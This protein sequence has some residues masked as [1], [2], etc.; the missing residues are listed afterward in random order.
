MVGSWNVNV[1]NKMPQK[2]ASA[3]SALSEQLMGAEYDF[4]AYLGF[5][6][7]NGTNHAV[8]AKQVVVTGR[9]TTNVVVIV[10]NEKP[11]NMELTLV[12]IDRVVEGGLPEGGIHI[13]PTMDIPDDAMDAWTDAFEGFTGSNVVPIALLGT[14]VVK[15]TNY[16]FAAEITPVVINGDSKIAVVTVNPMTK[17]VS[18]ADILTARQESSLGYAFTW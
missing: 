8:L 13:N 4:I 1:S 9:D 14:Q 2:V 16:I 5:Q 11:G 10:F 15:G 6:V 12:S 18:F 17:Q 3:M 7:V